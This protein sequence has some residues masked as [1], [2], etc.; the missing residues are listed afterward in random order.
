MSFK[1][2]PFETED[3]LAAKLIT[4]AESLFAASSKDILVL[5]ESS[6]KRFTTVLPLKVGNF[7][8][9]RSFTSDMSSARSS[10]LIA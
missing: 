10:N 4:S 6:K 1:D 7:L 8:I 2:S 3:P 9:S 5:V